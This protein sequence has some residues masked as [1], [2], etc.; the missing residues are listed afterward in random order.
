MAKYQLRIC[1]DDEN[2]LY[3]FDDSAIVSLDWAVVENDVGSLSVVLPQVLDTDYF[4]FM[5]TV[6]LERDIGAGFQIVEN[7]RWFL[8]DWAYGEDENGNAIIELVCADSN[9]I[10]D[11]YIVAYA[12][13]TS[14]S[15]KIDNFDDLCKLVV[16]ENIVSPTDTTRAIAGITVE[17]GSGNAPSD[18]VTLNYKN[19]LECCKDF[20]NSSFEA[21]T[22]LVFDMVNTGPGAFEMRTW[23]TQMGQDLT[24][25][26]GNSR[27]VSLKRPR[28]EYNY[29]GMRN[30]IYCL[31][32]G[33]AGSRNVKTASKSSWW[34]T[35]KFARRELATNCEKETAAA[36]Q[37][38]AKADLYKN[39]PRQ[40]I[41]GEIVDEPGM[42][43]GV[44]YGWGDL[45]TASYKGAEIDCHIVSVHGTYSKEGEQLS[46]T[47]KGET[48]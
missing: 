16:T 41:T 11:G 14:Q 25:D 43:Y 17:A 32:Q 45:I 33:S 1:D 38:Q 5:R 4:G 12:E 24:A 46:I 39:R 40:I 15:D 2:T 44:D 8:M 26:S 7:R 35:S 30:Y 10:L 20:A 23:T 13:K 34:A 22:Y 36:V 6:I 31:G 19:L 3:I 21:G 48:P 28:M 27:P 47:V 42:R 29:S 18:T 37:A 9:T